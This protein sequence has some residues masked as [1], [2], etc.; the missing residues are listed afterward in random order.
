MKAWVSLRLPVPP[1]GV[2]GDLVHRAGDASIRG[3]AKRSVHD[4]TETTLKQ[5]FERRLPH[6]VARSCVKNRQKRFES[7]ALL[8]F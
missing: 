6:L 4:T 7:F 1:R 5:S 8:T 2:G 3:S